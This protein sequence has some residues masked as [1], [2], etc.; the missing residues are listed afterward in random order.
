ME[1]G[2]HTEAIKAIYD[3]ALS[4]N[5]WQGALDAMI[6]V[7]EAKC[8]MLYDHGNLNA[9][10]YS[11]ETV[12]RFFVENREAVEEYNRM[13]R[14]GRGSDFDKQ[15]I[16]AMA[17]H[18]P[19]KVVRDDDLFTIDAAYLERPELKM[20]REVMGF[21]RRL[22]VR[23]SDDPERHVGWLLQYPNKVT[24]FPKSDIRLMEALAPHAAKA[25]EIHTLTQPLRLK[26]RAVLSVLDMIDLPILLFAGCGNVIVKNRAAQDIL[27]ERD[28]LWLDR[29]GM[30]CAR[31]ETMRVE[32]ANAVSRMT[33]T[34]R[35]ESF[36]RSIE[37]EISRG[38]FAPS[39]YA[40]ISPLRDVELELERGL[41]GAVMT[42]I[43]PSYPV[44]VRVD[45][46]AAAYGLSPAEARVADLIAVGRSNPAIA[47]MTNVSPETVKK[48]VSAVFEKTGTRSRLAFLWRVFQ[49]SPPVR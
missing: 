4:E 13:V 23:L 32:L 34:A 22:V 7:T 45:L 17:E 46:V 47:E 30:L 2:N 24:D 40:L 48:Q 3:A 16:L 36:D 41:E 39:I 11:V 19:L 1:S 49:F 27:S 44:R 43:D 26:Y 42:L 6:N 9:I 20:C 38:P 37:I 25:I 14:E 28:A 10:K 21:N 29:A 15:G 31:D 5:R 12:S 8:G 18:P 33:R 35:G